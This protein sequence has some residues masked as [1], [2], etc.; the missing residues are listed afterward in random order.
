MPRKT[1]DLQAWWD[2]VDAILL[3]SVWIGGGKDTVVIEFLKAA[4]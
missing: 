3:G 2:R 1:F 4:S